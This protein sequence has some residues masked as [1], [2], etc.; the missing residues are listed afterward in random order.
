ML[1]CMAFFGFSVVSTT[2]FAADESKPSEKDIMEKEDSDKPKPF[3]KVVPDAVKIPG[4]INLYQKKDN[5]YAEITSAQLDK[6]FI[7]VMSIAKG[8]GNKLLY[9]GQSLYDDDMVWQF[10]KIDDRIMIVRRNYRYQADSGTTEEKS[11]KLAYTDSIIFSLPVVAAG[12][13]GGD[14]VDLTPIFMSDLPGLSRWSIPGFG[15][16][17]DR[18]SWEKVK[19][20]DENIELEVAARIST[21]R[22]ASFPIQAINR[23][24][25]MNVSVILSPQSKT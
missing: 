25:P 17:K 19:G 18:S 11:I 6:D 10:R 16:A 23:V 4:L 14:M 24:L 3:D 20:F 13:G 9:A 2:L 5:L 15:F 21:T 22:S 8:I 7:V 1:I 12:P